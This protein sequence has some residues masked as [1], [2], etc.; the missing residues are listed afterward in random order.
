MWW[1]FEKR[2]FVLW[3]MELLPSERCCANGDSVCLINWDVL[4]FV[5]Q[6]EIGKMTYLNCMYL[7]SLRFDCHF[8]LM[9]LVLL[10]YGRSN[11]SL[12]VR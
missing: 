3:P 1:S 10:N 6:I 12:N 4:H 8:T 11:L 7:K 2:L 5:K 9:W